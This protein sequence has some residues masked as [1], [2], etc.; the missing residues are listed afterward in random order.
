[1]VGGIGNFFGPIA[2]SAIM[3]IIEELTS[4]Y[5]EHVELVMGL[6]LIA[7]ILFFPLGFMGIVQ[8]VKGKLFSK[9]S[10]KKNVENNS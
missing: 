2:G 5:T 1:M 4:R 10:T 9:K 7:V 6:I 3:G 8:I